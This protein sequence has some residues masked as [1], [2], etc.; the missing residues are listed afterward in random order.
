MKLPKWSGSQACD[1]VKVNGPEFPGII[2]KDVPDA[3]CPG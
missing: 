2:G 3:I 1:H